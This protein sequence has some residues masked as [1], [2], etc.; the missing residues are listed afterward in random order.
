MVMQKVVVHWVRKYYANQQQMHLP[1]NLKCILFTSWE[2]QIII[3]KCSGISRLE[4][5]RNEQH[6]NG[7]TFI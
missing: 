3:Y 4:F 5:L 1:L 7:H 2:L 6:L